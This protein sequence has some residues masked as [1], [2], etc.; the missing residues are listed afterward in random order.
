MGHYNV[1]ADLATA[2]TVE[3]ILPTERALFSV[4]ATI[5]HDVTRL[6]EAYMNVLSA[7][8]IVSCSTGVGLA[9]V[10]DDMVSV[11]LGAQWHAS[12]SLI[13]WLALSAAV[14][15]ICHGIVTVLNVAGKSRV[16]AR[17]SW[18][19]LAIFLPSFALAGA[20]WGVE[21][22]AI[23]R[24]VTMLIFGPLLFWSLQQVVRVSLAEIVGRVWRP[25]AAAG[26]MAIAVKL[27]HADWILAA[28]LRLFC[29]V[30]IGAF[31]FSTALMV[32]WMIAGR[33]PGLEAA[34][35]GYVSRLARVAFRSKSGAH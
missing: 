2:P 5:V 10:A 4:L 24:F 31:C 7:V 3:L 16:A 12:A 22:V 28:W 13:V 29:S 14:W 27:T 21:G 19:R 15:G 35:W 30:T 25:A 8:A 32:L 23:A 9:L 18:V 33:P 11:V 6:K 17:L 1:A 34:A 20:T 26:C